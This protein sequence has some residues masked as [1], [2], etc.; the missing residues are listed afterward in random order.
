MVTMAVKGEVHG[1]CVM[2]EDAVM[3]LGQSAL[4]VYVLRGIRAQAWVAMVK[5]LRASPQKVAQAVDRAERIAARMTRMRTSA[6]RPR[7][8]LF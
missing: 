4:G 8:R 5:A 7:R 2:G 3:L 1:G 6:P